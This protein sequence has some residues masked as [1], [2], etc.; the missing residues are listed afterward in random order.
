MPSY[1]QVLPCPAASRFLMILLH[2]EQSRAAIFWLTN[3][4]CVLG[5]RSVHLGNT[6]PEKKRRVRPLKPCAG[7]D[8]E[9]CLSPS[10]GQSLLKLEKDHD[11]E[12]TPTFHHYITIVPK[13]QAPSPIFLAGYQKGPSALY[14]GISGQC[15]RGA[16]ARGIAGQGSKSHPIPEERVSVQWGLVGTTVG[17]SIRVEGQMGI[18]LIFSI[19][20]T[21]KPEAPRSSPGKAFMEAGVLLAVSGSWLLTRRQF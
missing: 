14:P 4:V 3:E 20:D 16:V 5:W 18:P 8:V 2:Y 17:R 1:R 10:G 19:I 13:D 7:T 6:S 9:G 15:H 11:R 12:E 21:H